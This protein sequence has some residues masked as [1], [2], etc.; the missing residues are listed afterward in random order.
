M[1]PSATSETTVTVVGDNEKKVTVAKAKTPLE[2]LSHGPDG[3]SVPGIPKFV[4]FEN[5]RTWIL[6]HM[7]A[8]FRHWSREDYIEGISG[9]ISVLD[10]EHTNAFWFNPYG[11][12][13]GL[14]KASDMVLVHMDGEV[15]GGNKS[16]PVVNGAGFHIHTAVHKAR[17]D[18][19]A[20]CHC[21]GIHGKAWSVFGRRLEMLTQDT[22]KFYGEAQAVYDSHGGVVLGPEEGERIAE[23][24]GPKGK[25]VILRNHGILTVGTTVDEAAF[26]MTSIERS[27]RVQLLAEAAAANG[28]PKKLISDQEAQFNYDAESDADLCY[29][30]FQAEFNLEDRLSNGDFKN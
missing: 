24:L 1:A 15:I 9:H 28:I 7:A 14:L 26:L 8:V 13:F 22:C 20:V 10:P 27:C 5:E 25:A 11:V 18:A 12:H 6:E 19:H 4:S 16:W 21:H 2:A 29:A 3:L 30:E 17:P 23:S